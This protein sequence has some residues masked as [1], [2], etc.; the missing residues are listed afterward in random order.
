MSCGR[1]RAA[2]TVGLWLGTALLVLASGCSAVGRCTY[3]DHPT[4]TGEVEVVSIVQEGKYYMVEVR[5]LF[6]ETYTMDEAMYNSCLAQRGR[7]V[8]SKLPASSAPG[9]ACPP[10]RVLVDCL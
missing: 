3:G 10:V 5:G 9:G 6:S 4:E 2:A 1:A 7:D 8:G